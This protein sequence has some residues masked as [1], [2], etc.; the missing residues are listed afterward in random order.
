[1]EQTSALVGDIVGLLFETVALLHT[2]FE[3][4]AADCGLSAAQ[5]AAVQQL[6]RPLSMR[7]LAA[8]LGCDPSNVTGITD[9]LE[10]RGLVER[11]VA[12]SDRR[13]KTLVLTS[14]G[15]ELRERLQARLLHGPAPV[16][17][18]TRQQQEVLRD[19][20]RRALPRNAEGEREP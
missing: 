18:L 7:E 9:R 6:E 16:T 8:G 5:A 12:A 3:R 2:H 13:V 14:T 20:L 15:M 10:A 11:Q 1:M 17:G 4:C 19:L